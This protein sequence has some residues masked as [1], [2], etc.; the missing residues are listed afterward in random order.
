MLDSI[1]SVYSEF[2]LLQLGVKRALVGSRV[3]LEAPVYREPAC[4]ED[5]PRMPASWRVL[6]P[7]D[8]R[9]NT[10]CSGAPP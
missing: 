4:L 5:L 8:L 3:F 6:L 1:K 2:H 7:E 9:S 10:A